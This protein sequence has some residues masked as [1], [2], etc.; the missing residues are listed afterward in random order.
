H[1]HDHRERGVS[2]SKNYCSPPS[3]QQRCLFLSPEWRREIRL[4]PTEMVWVK[5]VCHSGSA[6]SPPLVSTPHWRSRTTRFLPAR[7]STSQRISTPQRIPG[8]KPTLP[9]PSR[10][11]KSLCEQA[12]LSQ[13]E[14]LFRTIRTN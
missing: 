3:Q 9:L 6:I 7:N 12:A 4:I 10:R 8:R 5:G 13:T 14:R 2:C 1:A 11:S